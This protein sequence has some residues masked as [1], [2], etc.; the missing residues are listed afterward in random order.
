MDDLDLALQR[1]H[2]CAPE[3]GDSGF[4]N[5]GPMAAEALVALGHPALIEALV[6]IYTPRLAEL[7]D[8][9]ELDAEAR[10]AA[11]GRWDAAPDWIETFRCAL[12]KHD[13]EAVLA[14]W[15]PTL[16]PGAFAAAGHGVIRVAHAVRALG[17]EATPQRI[18]EL[19]H[20]LGYWAAA[21]Q[22]L[23]GAPGT[24]PQRGRSAADVL[25]TLDFVSEPEPGATLIS[26]AVRALDR[27]PAFRDAVESI[28]LAAAQP[29]EIISDV[30]RASAGLYLAHPEL[31]I[32]YAH[33]VTAPAALR[34]L[35]PHLGADDQRAAAGRAL[36]CSA[37]IHATYGQRRANP[38][39][40][41]KDAEVIA[42]AAAPDEMRYRAA[43]SVEEH[44]IKLTEACLREDALAEDP[45][46]RLAA[47]D[48]A[49]RIGASR[50]ARG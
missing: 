39:A 43:C 31:R 21:F 5:H 18:E 11:L 34:L 8:G 50:G 36:Q 28:D 24:R 46:L 29:G 27:M 44:A 45:V 9:R 2:S 25:D 23:P 32:L 6:H 35:L 33:A 3:Y 12:A 48:A 1:F 14:E 22:P 15:L 49:I 42:L 13:V 17:R 7:A 10:A 20:G 38:G 37:A 19:A 30:V 41:S 26:E 16:L 4:S 47:A 40:P